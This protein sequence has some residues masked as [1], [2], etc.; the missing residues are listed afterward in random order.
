MIPYV[1]DIF[2]VFVVAELKIALYLIG[3]SLPPVKPFAHKAHTGN[4]V[5]V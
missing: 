1:R 4:G 5:P 2:A 3:K